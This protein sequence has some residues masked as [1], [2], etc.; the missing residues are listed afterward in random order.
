MRFYGK[1]AHKSVLLFLNQ[2]IYKYQFFMYIC[3]HILKIML[4]T[5]IDN[6]NYNQKQ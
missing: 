1:S 2:N 5:S 4:K 6:Y 3:S